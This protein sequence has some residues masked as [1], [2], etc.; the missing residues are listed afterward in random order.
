MKF[1]V[2]CD[3][4]KQFNLLKSTPIVCMWYFLVVVFGND[5]NRCITWFVR[6]TLNP[7]D[8]DWQYPKRNYDC[9][10]YQYWGILSIYLSFFCLKFNGIPLNFFDFYCHVAVL[11]LFEKHEKMSVKTSYSPLSNLDTFTYCKKSHPT[12]KAVMDKW[13][14]T[15]PEPVEFYIA[16]SIM[17][18]I[19]SVS[20][21]SSLDFCFWKLRSGSI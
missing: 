19:W 3:Q 7:F 8:N 14:S 6:V 12:I 5:R 18:P 4:Q 13:E 17:T 9:I 20:V 21:W 15:C 16:I 10:S 2:A 1:V 11:P